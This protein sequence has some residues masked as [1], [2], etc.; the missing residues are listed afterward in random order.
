M[1]Q[2]VRAD[3]IHM[4]GLSTIMLCVLMILLRSSKKRHSSQLRPVTLYM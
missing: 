2:A 1:Y 4:R 3:S